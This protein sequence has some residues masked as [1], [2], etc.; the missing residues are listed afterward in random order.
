MQQSILRLVIAY[1]SL[2]VFLYLFHVVIV[3][4][5]LQYFT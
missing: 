5:I 3:R 4:Q 1:V 2:V